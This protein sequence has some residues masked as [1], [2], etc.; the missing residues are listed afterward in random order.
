MLGQPIHI[1]ELTCRSGA[2]PHTFRPAIRCR[3]IGN[4]RLPFDHAVLVQKISKPHPT[5]PLDDVAAEH[6]V[7]KRVAIGTSYLEP[8]E[9][10]DLAK[11]H[12]LLHV[13]HFGSDHIESL[14]E[15]EAKR[16]MKI[17]G[18]PDVVNPFP[19]IDGGELSP[20]GCQNR[21]QGGGLGRTSGRT[22]LVREMKPEF[23]P[24][25][26]YCLKCGQFDIGVTGEAT[27]IKAPHVIAGLAM[28]DLLRQKPA[29]AATFA[30]ARAQANDAESVSL[31]GD[32]SDQRRTVNSVRDGAIDDGVNAHFHECGHAGKGTFNHIGH[33]VQIIGAKRIDEIRINPVHAPD[34]AILFIEADQ[35]PVLFLAAVIIR[36]RA[37]QQWHAMAG[38]SN[39]SDFLGYEILVLH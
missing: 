32:R 1:V 4:R 35:Q 14:V 12:I 36:D 19:S 20:F 2:I 37:A 9:A 23:V 27:G 15:V 21:R 31:A 38:L 22:M 3:Q 10:T 29:M 17:R 16:R 7:K 5:I 6:P 11:P 28:N 30:E 13:R 39:R 18:G 25:I 33:A 8:V 24:V 34:P 26:L